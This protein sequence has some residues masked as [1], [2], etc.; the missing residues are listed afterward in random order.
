MC[1]VSPDLPSR[2]SRN[3]RTFDSLSEL[4]FSEIHRR[5]AWGIVGLLAGTAIG[6]C[7]HQSLSHR[8]RHLSIPSCTIDLW[9][10]ECHSSLSR[11]PAWPVLRSPL[12]ERPGIGSALHAS[13]ATKC[14]VFRLFREFGKP[15]FRRKLLI[16]RELWP[17]VSRSSFDEN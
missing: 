13:H 16:N 14:Y 2:M 11:L 8:G 15:G 7:N 10:S 6:S 1:M 5:V 4:T 17:F 9:I 12:L 3:G